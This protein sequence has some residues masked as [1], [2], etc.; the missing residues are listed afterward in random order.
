[1]LHDAMGE[2]AIA[3]TGGREGVIPL[4]NGDFQPVE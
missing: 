2:P 4:L 1:M 3:P